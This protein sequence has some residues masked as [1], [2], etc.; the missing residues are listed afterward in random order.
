MATYRCADCGHFYKGEQEQCPNCGAPAEAYSEKV[1]QDLDIKDGEPDVE[2]ALRETLDPEFERR[3]RVKKAN[4]AVVVK[5]DMPFKE[6]L[7]LTAKFYIAFLI[8]QVVAS[9]IILAV[10][11]VLEIRP[12][13]INIL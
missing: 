10:L 9:L 6:I 1:S 12:T 2:E 4:D 13:G 3:K 11:H 5:V 7:F 8:C